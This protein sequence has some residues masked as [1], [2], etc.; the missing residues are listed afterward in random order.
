MLSNDKEK[1]I[2]VALKYDGNKDNAP[3]VIAKGKGIIAENIISKGNDEGIKILEDKL[4]AHSL[5]KLEIAEEIPE[6]L[7]VAVAEILSFIYGLDAEREDY[8]K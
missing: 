4:L 8:G 2:A 1:K 6:E 7:Y 5:I 3:Y